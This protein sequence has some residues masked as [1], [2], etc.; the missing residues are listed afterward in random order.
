MPKLR[1][2]IALVLLICATLVQIPKS[3]LHVCHSGEDFI[4]VHTGST[5]KAHCNVCDH[6]ALIAETFEASIFLFQTPF[7]TKINTIGVCRDVISVPVHFH[8][9]APPV[10]PC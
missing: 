5:Y 7:S 6:E 2:H 9:K 8:N 4:A 3:W 10:L 1:R